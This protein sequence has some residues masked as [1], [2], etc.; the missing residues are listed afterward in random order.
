MKP[1]C[2]ARGG[3]IE[4][5]LTQGGGGVGMGRWEM[6]DGRW[7]MDRSVGGLDRSYLDMSTDSVDFPFW[8]RYNVVVVRSG[9]DD[10]SKCKT[11]G[12]WV[13][14]EQNP[15]TSTFGHFCPLPHSKPDYP[16]CVQRH[17]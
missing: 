4:V 3:P 12:F 8:S 2:L 14:N 9:M 1:H 17:T 11:I 10:K 6:G 16:R 13:W 15:R 7:E 5:Q